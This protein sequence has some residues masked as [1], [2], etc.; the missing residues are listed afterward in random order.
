[1]Q[2]LDFGVMI[3]SNSPPNPLCSH[4]CPPLLRS[5]LRGC[6]LWLDREKLESDL[7]R[8]RGFLSKYPS[9]PF[10]GGG[11]QVRVCTKFDR[12]PVFMTRLFSRRHV[13]FSGMRPDNTSEWRPGCSV[14]TMPGRSWHSERLAGS[15][16]E[17]ENHDRCRGPARWL[18]GNQLRPAA[19]NLELANPEGRTT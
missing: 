4:G 3:N 7:D 12:R 13:R 17:E 5:R 2:S 11:A 18:R 10:H 6:H 16:D 14:S 8:S 1:M 15:P 9:W 19:S